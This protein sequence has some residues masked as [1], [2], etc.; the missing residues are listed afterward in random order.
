MYY[1]FLTRYIK[2]TRRVLKVLTEPSRLSSI[3]TQAH[4]STQE[5][6]FAIFTLKIGCQELGDVI[7]IHAKILFICLILFISMQSN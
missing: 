5:P 1:Y 4:N 6:N 2:S 3:E 7:Y